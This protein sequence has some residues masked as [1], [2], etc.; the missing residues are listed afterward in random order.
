MRDFSPI[1]YRLPSAKIRVTEEP[2]SVAS[3]APAGSQSNLETG[4]FLLV[5]AE[6]VALPET[7]VTTET[8]SVVRSCAVAVSSRQERGQE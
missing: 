4:P 3:T 5:G 8:A 6:R 7:E 1:S 2:G